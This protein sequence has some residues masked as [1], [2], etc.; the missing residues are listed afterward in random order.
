MSEN[1]VLPGQ[2][3]LLSA[4]IRDLNGRETE[5]SGFIPMFQIEES[6]NFDC[7]TGYAEVHDNVGHLERLPLR[8][9][10]D[11]VI[12][13]EDVL[14]KRITYNL[15]IYKITNVEINNANDGLRYFIYFVS[16]GRYQATFRRIIRPF[17][18]KTSD[19]AQ[20]IYNEYYPRDKSLVKEDTSGI[21]RCVIPNYTP[22]QAMNFLVSRSYST[23]SPSCS[24]KFFE[25]SENFYFVS[26]EYLIKQAKQNRASIKEFTFSSAVSKS[27]EEF[28]SQMQNLVEI[29][30]TDRVNTMEDLSSG[31]YRSN[32]I[33][34]D[35]MKRVVNMPGIST[36]HSYDY[37]ES[38]LKYE[39]TSGQGTEGRHTENFIQ[40]YFTQENEKRYVVIKDYG[41]EDD[42]DQIRGDQFLPE[43]VTNRK[44]YQHHL[45]NT[46]LYA[47]ANGRL[48]LNAGSMINVKIPEF[49][50]DS[51]RGLN[52]QLSGYYLIDTVTH[53][54]VRDVHLT[55]L[56]L[57][58]YDWSTRPD[59]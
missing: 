19:I 43:I 26:D 22:I 3:K 14:G 52:P 34:I 12:E 1:F 2:F 49:N 48:D 5:F 39:S 57:L 11:F 35:I 58:K 6:I 30:N 32:V 45:N 50:S 44:A 21:F 56:K 15:K 38:R 53:N 54:F 41:D 24:F 25:T 7:I 47:K 28:D 8:G 10:E 31:S 27:G 18:N 17:R 23:S 16:K 29:K 59:A 42:S 4:I 20:E 36:E 40:Q 37:S 46:L 51:E 33:E 9:E 13:V 55:S